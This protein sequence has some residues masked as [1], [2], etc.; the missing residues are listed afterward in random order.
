MA[1]YILDVDVIKTVEATDFDLRTIDNT[2][3]G[4]IQ[5]YI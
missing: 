1:K 5:E 4:K 2:E 3:T